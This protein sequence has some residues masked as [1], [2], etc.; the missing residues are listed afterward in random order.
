MNGFKILC[1]ISKV[2]FEISHQNFE[3]I[4]RKIFLLRRVK[5]LTTHDILELWH[6]SLSE[7][8]SSSSWNGNQHE[9]IYKEPLSPR[10]RGAIYMTTLCLDTAQR[11]G[12]RPA[13]AQEMAAN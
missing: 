10:V 9:I 2:P 12:T 7:T 6:L 11:N 3:P 1:E 13:A 4:H 8:G 5:K